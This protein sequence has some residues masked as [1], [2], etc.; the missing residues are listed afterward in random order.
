MK[1]SSSNEEDKIYSKA[2][3]EKDA[4][5]RSKN[6]DLKKGMCLVYKCTHC[7]KIRHLKSF[8]FKLKIFKG[9]QLRSFVTNGGT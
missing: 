9:N 7:N 5:S 6:K 3:N 4:I 2:P 1:E 8:C